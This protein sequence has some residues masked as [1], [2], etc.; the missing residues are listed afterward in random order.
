MEE[1]CLGQPGAM[2]A[3]AIF[4]MEFRIEIS[5]M[6]TEDS[7]RN[8]IPAAAR[9]GYGVALPL[10]AFIAYQFL[11]IESTSGTGSWHGMSIFFSSLFSVPVLLAANCWVIAFRWGGKLGAFL[12]G[13]ALP[14]VVMVPEYMYL[15]GRY[16]QAI[17]NAVSGGHRV[18]WLFVFLPFLP[19]LV[20]ILHAICRRRADGRVAKP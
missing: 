18:V 15:D 17:H 14:L 13:M 10:A 3:L 1:C 8:R 19:L 20:A 5:R 6:S 7:I 12:A 16:H 4:Q 11:L 2:K 9:M